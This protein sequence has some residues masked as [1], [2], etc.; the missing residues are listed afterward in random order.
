MTTN[1]FTGDA[2]WATG[3]TAFDAAYHDLLMTW[4]LPAATA[5]VLQVFSTHDGLTT[6][7]PD[8]KVTLGEVD[9]DGAARQQMRFWTKGPISV[10]MTGHSGNPVKVTVT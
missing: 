6:P 8:A 1:T 7:V 10:V 5:G 2:T 4:D 9:G 3:M